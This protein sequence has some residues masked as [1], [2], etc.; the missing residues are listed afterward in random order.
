MHTGLP[1][2]CLSRVLHTC[3]LS[4]RWLI[5][6]CAAVEPIEKAAPGIEFGDNDRVPQ[7]ILGNSFTRSLNPQKNDTEPEWALAWT[8]PSPRY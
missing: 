3:A 8:K 2:T 5:Q 1:L 6:L 4:A 7:H